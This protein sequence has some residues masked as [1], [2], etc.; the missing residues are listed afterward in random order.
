MVR[1]MYDAT[2]P[3]AGVLVAKNPEMV[4]IYLTGGPGIAW[5]SA[6]VQLF[7]STVKFVRI[8]QA[9]ATAP[10]HEAHVMDVEPGAYR[11]ADVPGWTSKC[12]APRPTVYC[13]RSDLPAVMQVWKGDIWLAAPG[14]SLAECLAITANNKQVIAVQNVFGGSFDSSVVIDPN[15][16]E[17][18]PVPP[19]P[20]PPATVFTVQVERYQP[21]FGWVLEST[22]TTKP[23]TRYR[24]RVNNSKAWSP[25]QQF[26]V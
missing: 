25:W 9:G 6:E 16:P 13:D 10:Q 4:A 7:K 23:G 26:D 11:P 8:D 19:P 17:K 1:T 21:G 18:A 20:P 22:F 5:T 12:T 24:A 14:L 2:G 15:W 3:N